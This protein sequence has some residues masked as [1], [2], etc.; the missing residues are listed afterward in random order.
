MCDNKKTRTE[1]NT[2]CFTGHRSVSKDEIPLLR[3]SLHNVIEK[4]WLNGYRWFIC[5]GAVGFDTLAAEE[6]LSFRNLHPEIGLLL[7]IPCEN[8]DRCWAEQDRL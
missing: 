4:C 3:D 6:I 5:G 2:V 7:A 8:Q 1:Q